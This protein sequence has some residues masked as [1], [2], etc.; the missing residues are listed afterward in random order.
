VP[1]EHSE[2]LPNRETSFHFVQIYVT[3]IMICKLAS[4]ILFISSLASAQTMPEREP[5]P[6]TPPPE[7]AAAPATPSGEAPFPE[8][9]QYPLT[10]FRSDIN[11]RFWI[12]GDV[13]IDAAPPL[14]GFSTQGAL[15]AHLNLNL[16]I[17][18][19]G[20]CGAMLNYRNE[21]MYYVDPASVHDMMYGVGVYCRVANV[22]YKRKGMRG[23]HVQAHAL[24]EYGRSDYS[25]D[26]SNYYRT[27]SGHNDAAAV[28]VGGDFYF[29]LWFGFWAHGGPS[30]EI[31]SFRYEA[32][33]VSSGELTKSAGPNLVLL[34]RVGLSYSFL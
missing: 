22:G 30:L 2:A 14:N 6:A 18:V 20:R 24:V 27:N 11:S 34:L 5:A 15:G 32:P 10:P 28:T 21:S 29:P 1:A 8:Y 19:L 13:G 33:N 12:G 7:A 9:A 3:R 4:T 25:F 16:K 26:P 17:H 23:A 31:N